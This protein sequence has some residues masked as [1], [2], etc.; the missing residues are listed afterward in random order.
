M[1][2][3]VLLHLLN[4][5]QMASDVSAHQPIRITAA[6]MPVYSLGGSGVCLTLSGH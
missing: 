4:E 1:A 3:A 2:S 5:Q 6:G